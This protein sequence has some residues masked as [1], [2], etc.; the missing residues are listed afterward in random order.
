M[1]TYKAYQF[2]I[3]VKAEEISSV[4][5]ATRKL[6]KIPGYIAYCSEMIDPQGRKLWV[7]VP[8]HQI[9]PASDPDKDSAI[10]LLADRI[11]Q[12]VDGRPATG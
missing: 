3:K 7:T 2:V 1:P 8:P 5:P 11:K 10:K 9:P 4:D 6:V 12:F